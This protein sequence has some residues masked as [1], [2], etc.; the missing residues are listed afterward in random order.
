VNAPR[1]A[2]KFL[3]CPRY[4]SDILKTSTVVPSAWFSPSRPRAAQSRTDRECDTLQHLMAVWLGTP[5]L[6]PAKRDR[7]VPCLDLEDETG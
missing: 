4:Q 2:N 6:S 3:R 7:V 5:W 1:A